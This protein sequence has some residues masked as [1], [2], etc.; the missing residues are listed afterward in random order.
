MNLILED[1]N[2]HKPRHK[3]HLNKISFSLQCSHFSISKQFITIAIWISSHI[4]THTHTH[5]RVKE[6]F[7]IFFNSD[8]KVWAKIFWLF[9]FS[10]FWAR[11]R[12]HLKLDHSHRPQMSDSRCCCNNV[13]K[14]FDLETGIGYSQVMRWERFLVSD[15]CCSTFE[16]VSQFHSLV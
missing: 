16:N 2:L 4:H 9:A 3:L 12:A 1:I 6:R 7:F 14:Q 13:S 11:G 8:L 15:C 10:E 5:T